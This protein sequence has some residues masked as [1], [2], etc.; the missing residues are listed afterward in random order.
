MGSDARGASRNAGAHAFMVGA[1]APATKGHGR[2][3]PFQI[4]NNRPDGHGIAPICYL[5]NSF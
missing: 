3:S 2:H 4:Q 1:T 5:F